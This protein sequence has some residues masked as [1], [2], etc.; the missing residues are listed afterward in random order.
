MDE[1]EIVEETAKKTAKLVGK[2]ILK[3]GAIALGF[4]AVAIGLAKVLAP[5]D[6][7]VEVFGEEEV[8]ELAEHERDSEA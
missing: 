6:Q 5:E 1:D 2:K 3:F 7:Y 4:A 8:A